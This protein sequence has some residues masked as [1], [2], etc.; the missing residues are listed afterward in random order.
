MEKLNLRVQ[1]LEM[2]QN[3][4]KLL[5]E[6]LTQYNINTPK[7]DLELMKVK[8]ILQNFQ[9]FTVYMKQNCFIAESELFLCELSWC[10]LF[11]ETLSVK[12]CG[13]Y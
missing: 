8:Y 10:D 5:N 13:R 12:R 2:V 6:M 4:V 7:S 3:N 9:R 11:L 1:E